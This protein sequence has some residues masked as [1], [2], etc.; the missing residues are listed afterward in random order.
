MTFTLTKRAIRLWICRIFIAAALLILAEGYFFYSTRLFWYIA[1]A[2]A[3][4]TLTAAVI[5][6][7]YLKSYSVTV[8]NSSLTVSKGLII[9]NTDIMPFARL[10]FGAGY[11]T[12]FARLLGLQAVVLRAAR[13]II[14]IPELPHEDAQY[15]LGKISG[16]SYEE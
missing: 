11:R 12:P 16:G 7:L 5:L 1:A 10:V 8:N 14:I 2:T 15:L 9:K 13:G 3:L 6:P 4:L